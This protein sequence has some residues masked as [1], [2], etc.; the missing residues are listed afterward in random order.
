VWKAL[1]IIVMQQS[2]GQAGPDELSRGLEAKPLDQP[3]FV[4]ALGKFFDRFGQFFQSLEMARP[5]KLPLERVRSKRS[6]LPLPSGSRT[7]AGE[8]SRPRTRISR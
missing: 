6:M 3:L 8:D 7:N 2:R 1:L 5:E 4:V